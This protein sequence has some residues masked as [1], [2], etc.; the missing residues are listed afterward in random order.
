MECDGSKAMYNCGK[1]GQQNALINFYQTQ[2]YCEQFPL[3]R[4]LRFSSCHGNNWACF[5]ESFVLDDNGSFDF[6]LTWA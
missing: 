1:K 4:G 6:G 5:R 3:C 2:A